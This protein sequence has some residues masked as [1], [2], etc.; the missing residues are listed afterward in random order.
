MPSPLLLDSMKVDVL[1][2]QPVNSIEVPQR[3]VIN[4]SK[5]QFFEDYEST[6]VQRRHRKIQSGEFEPVMMPQSSD[7]ELI[8]ILD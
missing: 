3:Y 4:D 8:K 7:R 5:D 2:Q 6:P 1:I